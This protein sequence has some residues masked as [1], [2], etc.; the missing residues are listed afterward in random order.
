MERSEAGAGSPIDHW[1]AHV[2]YDAAEKPRAERLRAAIA[3]RF[4]HLPLGRW[5]DAPVGP[6]PRGSYQVTIAPEDFAAVVPWL[7]V[8]RGGVTVF[9]HPDTGDDLADH[10]DHVVW[11]GPSETLN[12]DSFRRRAAARAAAA[13]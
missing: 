6:H 1:H 5:H 8:A 11:L 12:L 3:A 4:P 7:A 9:V 10:S 13:G 2:Y